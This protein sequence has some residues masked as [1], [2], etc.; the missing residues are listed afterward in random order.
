MNLARCL[1]HLCAPPW[2][3]GRAF[4]A[5][6]LE[7][8]EQAVEASET[9]HAGELRVVIEGA[10]HPLAALRGHSGRE[11]AIEIFS[12]LRIWDTAHNS[13]VL[14]YLLMADH[15]IEIIADRGIQSAVGDAEWA[16]L[17][18][19]L[20]RRFRRSEFGDGMLEAVEAV[21]QALARHFP[22]DGNSHNELPDRVVVL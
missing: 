14:I 21:T 22:P 20:E 11:R 10:L 4:P 7:A 5:R 9:R 18:E 2:R 6:T 15:D 17:C 8:I 13:G 12:A 16:A 3:V 1:R 19:R